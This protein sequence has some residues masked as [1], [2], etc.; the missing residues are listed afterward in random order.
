MSQ[1]VC[2]RTQ[3]PLTSYMVASGMTAIATNKSATA[4][5]TISQLDGVLSLRTILTAV[6]TSTLPTIVPVMMTRQAM[7]I[8]TAAHVGYLNRST[9][10][11][12]VTAAEDATTASSWLP[13]VIKTVVGRRCTV[14]KTRYTSFPFG[15]L[16][17]GVV[18]ICNI[19]IPHSRI[20]F[21]GP[22][23]RQKAVFDLLEINSSFWP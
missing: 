21:V 16:T 13:S 7:M 1:T 15:R 12:M 2:P 5:E 3:T 4:R 22:N 20:H 9:A 19:L 6:Q 10:V 11:A 18:F 17:S 23:F 8:K 14:Q